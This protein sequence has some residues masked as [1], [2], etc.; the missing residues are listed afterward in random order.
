[1]EYVSERGSFDDLPFE[2]ML[3]VFDTAYG[4]FL[5]T[6]GSEE[7]DEAFSA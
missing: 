5:V 2:A 6:E 4:D 1:M 7:P 3:E